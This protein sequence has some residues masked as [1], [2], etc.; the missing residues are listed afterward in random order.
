MGS[1]GGRTDSSGAG[2]FERF[3]HASQHPDLESLLSEHLGGTSAAE[4][5]VAGI[6]EQRRKREER[7]RP[8][9]DRAERHAAI[10]K[11]VAAV[12]D[13]EER[14]PLWTPPRA[15]ISH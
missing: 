4:A 1:K 10:A 15:P 9:N 3:E 13:A 5:L 11:A 6:R 7:M 2:E 12:S 8:A 14:A